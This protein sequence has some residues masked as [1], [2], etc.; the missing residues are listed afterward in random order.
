MAGATAV[1]ERLWLFNKKVKGTLEKRSRK[2]V[3]KNTLSVS[4]PL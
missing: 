4:T 2:S 1:K 3:S